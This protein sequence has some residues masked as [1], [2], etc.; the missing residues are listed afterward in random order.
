MSFVILN[1]SCVYLGLSYLSGNGYVSRTASGYSKCACDDNRIVDMLCFLE[2]T[3]YC[4]SNLLFIRIALFS[5]NVFCSLSYA[6]AILY[7]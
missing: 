1:I 5:T 6:N 4:F 3:F 2:E 7:H